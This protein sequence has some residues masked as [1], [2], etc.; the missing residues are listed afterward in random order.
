MKKIA[1]LQKAIFYIA[2][3]IVTL[4]ALFYQFTEQEGAG[5]KFG[6]LG[7]LILIFILFLYAYKTINI[8]KKTGTTS[9]EREHARPY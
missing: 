6:L 4:G 5:G 9:E 8:L 2:V 1:S 3:Q 7:T